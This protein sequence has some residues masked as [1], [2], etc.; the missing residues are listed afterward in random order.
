MA[1]P[2]HVTPDDPA[3]YDSGHTAAYMSPEQ[4]RGTAVDKRADIWGFGCVFYEM[5][6]GARAFPGESRQRG[7]GVCAG[8][9]TRLVACPADVP[10]VVVAY[11]KRCLQKDPKQR[12]HDIADVRLALDGAFDGGSTTVPPRHGG[13]WLVAAA[14]FAVGA[15]AAV[16]LT[17]LRTWPAPTPR[18]S[19][20]EV[21]SSRDTQLALIDAQRHIAITPDGSRVVYTANGGNALLVRRLDALEPA[22]AGVPGH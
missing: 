22:D 14:A 21:A 11:V 4:A 15:T 2:H 18:V 1:A 20:L 8:A 13:V 16:V 3:G 12:V 7:A 9:R 10:P 5:L 6:T 19:R 17:L